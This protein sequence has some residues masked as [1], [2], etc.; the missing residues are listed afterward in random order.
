[1]TLEVEPLLKEITGKE[2]ETLLAL[3]PNAMW[4]TS[5][6]NLSS[7]V[8]TFRLLGY[9]RKDR[10]FGVGRFRSLGKR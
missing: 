3:I 6:I 5:L 2:E 8:D 9:R 10:Y 4:E 1:M 7:Y